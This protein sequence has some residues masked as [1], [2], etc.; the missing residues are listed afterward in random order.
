VPAGEP[1]SQSAGRHHCGAGPVA[2]SSW[3]YRVKSGHH[4]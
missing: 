3:L 4:P 1:A 2:I